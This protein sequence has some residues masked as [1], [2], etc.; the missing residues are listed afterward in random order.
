MAITTTIMTSG[1][2]RKLAGPED[3]KKIAANIVKSCPVPFDKFQPAQPHG[4]WFQPGGS[5]SPLSL[6]AGS[7]ARVAAQV[8][9]GRNRAAQEESRTL[10]RSKVQAGL[11]A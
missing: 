4:R 11:T 7:S 5:I 6:P 2:P 3:W 10:F 8:S 9:P 1:L